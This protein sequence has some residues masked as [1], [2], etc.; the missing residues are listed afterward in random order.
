MKSHLRV[1]RLVAR[2]GVKRSMGGPTLV[3][4]VLHIRR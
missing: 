1:G 2:S 4:V 3:L